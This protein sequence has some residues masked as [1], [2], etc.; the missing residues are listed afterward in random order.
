MQLCMFQQRGHSSKNFYNL[1]GPSTHQQIFFCTWLERFANC[2]QSPTKSMD[3][4]WELWENIHHVALWKR[5]ILDWAPK[6]G[7][8]GAGIV[9]CLC[10]QVIFIKALNHS[11]I[12]HQPTHF[13]MSPW[14]SAAEV[15]PFDAFSSRLCCDSQIQKQQPK[16]CGQPPIDDIINASGWVPQQ[17]GTA[18]LAI[19]ASCGG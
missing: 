18:K 8:F 5:P 7:K 19:R 13:F 11:T 15:C 12:Q 6:T 16:T 9:F 10:F 17:F 14:T 1:F 2:C 3:T 4:S